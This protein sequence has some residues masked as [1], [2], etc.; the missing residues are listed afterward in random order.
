VSSKVADLSITGT[1]PETVAPGSGFSYDFTV[2]NAGPKGATGVVLSDTLPSGITFSSAPPGCT[3]LGGTVTCALG[4]IAPGASV[5]ISISVTAGV[6]GKFT[7]T[8]S[9]SAQTVDPTP[10]DASYTMKVTVA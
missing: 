2:H 4:T 3:F 9:V 5:D 8:A 7:D 6:A 1:A 10:A